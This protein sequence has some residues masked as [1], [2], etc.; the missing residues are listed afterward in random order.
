M[1]CCPRQNER[2]SVVSRETI[3]ASPS[4]RFPHALNIPG[5]TALTGAARAVL[6]EDGEAPIR[7]KKLKPFRISETTVTNADFAAFVDETGYQTDAERL[8]WSF[9]FMSQLPADHAPTQGVVGVEWWRRVDGASW[10][11]ITG[12]GCDLIEHLQDHPVVHVS[13]NDAKAFCAW[14]GG[15]LPTEAE[16]EHA[17]R[18]GLGDVPFPWGDQDPNDTEFTPCNIW[19]GQ[20]PNVNSCADGYSTTAPAKSFE[21]NEFGIYNMVGNVWEW[22]SEPFRVRS[23]KRNARQKQAHMIGHKL[24]K[25]GSFLCHKSYCFRYRIAARIGNTPDSTTTHMGFRVAWDN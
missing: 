13:W 3:F 19:Q 8:G 15:R 10:R 7:K 20:F 22:T 9:V 5:G 18:G 24:L 11:H 21:P 23:Q 17:A 4:A 16:W 12:P 1:A 2:G 6:P 25:G 14:A